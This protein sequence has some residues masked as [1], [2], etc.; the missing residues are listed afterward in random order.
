MF[1]IL[2]IS[3]LK[4]EM[5][6]CQS[7][8]DYYNVS[9]SHCLALGETW[10]TWPWNFDNIGNAFV[11]LF[12]LSSLEGWPDV[13]ATVFDAGKAEDGPSYNGNV[14]FGAIYFITFIIIGALFLMNLFV[15]V[16]F[17][18]F[19][20]EQDAEKKERYKYVSDDQMKWIQMQDLIADAKPN[21][22]VTAPPESKYR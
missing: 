19:Q 6:Y 12:V 11:T 21:F 16:I 4:D 20:S 10:A 8:D 18:Q 9:K 22:D 3:F 15:G 5:G 2:A 17:L 1:A 13:M 7:L 14:A